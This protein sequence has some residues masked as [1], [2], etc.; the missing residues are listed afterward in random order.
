MTT[1]LVLSDDLLFSSKITGTATALGLTVRVARTPAVL[2]EWARQQ[3]PG[4]VLVDLHHPQLDLA[5]LL[6][7]LGDAHVVGFGSHVEAATLHAA[8]QAGCHLVLP[9]SKFTE[10]LPHDLPQW[11]GQQK[12]TE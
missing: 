9:R 2:L 6:P 12:P 8:R 1:G 3:P 11:L 7:A 10:R 5:T 4:G